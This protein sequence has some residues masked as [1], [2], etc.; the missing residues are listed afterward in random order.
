MLA[1][2]ALTAC[3]GKAQEE[4]LSIEPTRIIFETDMGNDVDDALA[5]DMLFKYIDSEKIDLLGISTNKRDDGSL[6]YIDALTTWYGYPD[7][8]DRKSV[9]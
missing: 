3:S 4:I 6:E 1:A 2:G 7:I 8:P 5:M 9:V